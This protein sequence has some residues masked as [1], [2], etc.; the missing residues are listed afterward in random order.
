[1]K[2]DW[3]YNKYVL[4]IDIIPL[5]EN[6]YLNPT[7]FSLIK[8]EQILHESF[9]STVIDFAKDKISQTVDKIKDWKD[10]AVV[11]AK[12]LSNGELLND[13]LGPLGR[14]VG[15][16]VGK[17]KEF[18]NKVGLSSLFEKVK[19]LL[20]KV[21]GEKGWK[22]L[23]VYLSLGG[24]LFYVVEK[25]KS[26][27]KEKIKEYI[28][29]FLSLSTLETILDKLTD[30]TT[31]VGWLGPIIGGVATLYEFLKE[32]LD[33]FS[34][35]IK[36]NSKWATKLIKEKEN[37]M[38]RLKKKQI[39]EEIYNILREEDDKK[40]TPPI[41]SV[42]KLGDIFIKTGKDL[43]GG[44]IKGLDSG[45]LKNIAILLDNV[46]TKAGDSSSSSILQRLS[47]MVASK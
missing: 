11:F 7:L 21:S 24:I 6:E 41:T 26:L 14:R 36:D 33:K 17:F 22:K 42:S 46:F 44:K 10:A 9:L 40:E 12:I 23:L 45:E 35:A 37:T 20:G 16:L 47:K 29:N 2:L 34:D 38:D 28:T 32:L 3:K 39:R 25:G 15:K 30:W 5:N 1:M 27:S 13:F 4:G 19:T 8:E 31:Y 18:L 43:K